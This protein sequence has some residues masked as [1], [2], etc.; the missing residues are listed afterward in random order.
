MFTFGFSYIGVIYLLMLFIPNMIW[1]KNLPQ[2]YSS[3]GEN[4]IFR[5]FERVG[6][7]LCSCCVLIFS[8]FNIHVTWWIIWLGISLILMILYELYWIRYF[9][10]TKTLEDLYKP[11]L[12]IEV[13]GATLP[14]IAFFILGI[15]GT[16]IFMIVSSIILG[17]GH[18]GI[19]RC[20]YRKLDPDK[21]KLGIIILKGIV[22]TV[23]CLILTVISFFICA[24][25]INYMKHYQL[26]ENGVDEGVYVELG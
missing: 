3:E 10:S 12:G 17:I 22:C 1:A 24:R 2:G 23:L 19:H 11:F 15:Y 6:E 14:V 8:D 16:N 7:V 18:I 4:R 26:I 25:N 21:D 5:A 20:H 13:P 9:K